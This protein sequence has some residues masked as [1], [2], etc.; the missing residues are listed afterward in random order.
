MDFYEVLDQVVTLLRTRGRVTY[1]ALKLQFHLDNE[2]METLKEELIEAQRV[3]ADE[4]GKVLVWIGGATVVS[5]QLSVASPSQ[6][7]P[8]QTVDSGLQI[9][10]S[11]PQTLDPR[12]SAGERRQLTVMFCDLVDSTALSAQ[13]DPE[14]LREVVRAYQQACA[15]VIGRFEGH[16]AQYLGDGLLVYFGYP[17]AHEDDARRAVRS[18]LEIIQAL[19]KWAPSL[20]AG[21]GQ[22]QSRARQQ[23]ANAPLPHGRG[24]DLPLQGRK[25]KT[26]LAQRLQVRIGIHTGLVV[27]G[28]VG[29]GERHE[30]LAL[31]ET[32]NVAARLQ[33]LAAPDTVV[34]SAAT[35]RLVQSA[36]TLEEFGTQQLKGVT[37]HNRS[38]RTRASRDPEYRRRH[39]AGGCSLSGRPR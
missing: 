29:K 32:P 21:E 39:A 6:P 37:E 23:A 5:S 27:V 14:D 1:R 36:F 34:I 24:S 13:L 22:D 35:T 19:Q 18:G 31:G 3:A 38:A 9:A 28:E 17:R 20:L 2:H 15:E 8:S 11:K 26:R 30:Q 25:E 16:I 4:D 10:D 12:P 7:P 33:G